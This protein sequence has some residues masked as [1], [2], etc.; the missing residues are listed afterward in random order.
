MIPIGGRPILWHIMNH[1]ARHGFSDFILC[2]G[3]KSWLIKRYFLDYHLNG[4]DFTVKLASPNQ[5]EVHAT[6]RT[7]EDW[8]V[9]LAETGLDSMTGCRVKRIEKYID[10]DSFHLTYGDGVADVNLHAL[11]EFHRAHGKIGTVTAVQPSSR[12]GEIKLEGHQV[13]EFNEKPLVPNARI[14]GGF[15][16]LQRSIFDRLTDTP[17]LIFEYAPLMQLARDGELMAYPHDGFWHPMDTSR[18]YK[19]LNDLWTEGRAPWHTE[20]QAPLRVAA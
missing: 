4:A 8:R 16:V 14:S 12:F 18:D 19:H 6:G 11:V 10:G 17:E 13:V 1:Y 9:T 7:E 5:V 15:F 20:G 2:L 3:Y